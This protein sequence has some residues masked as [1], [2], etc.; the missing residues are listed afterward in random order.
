MDEEP[1]SH[2]LFRLFCLICGAPFSLAG[3]LLVYVA[4]DQWLNYYG[5]EGVWIIIPSEI[6]WTI[7]VALL[8]SGCVL[9][10]FVFRRKTVWPGSRPVTFSAS[11]PIP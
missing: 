4:T 3:L 2:P 9:L 5:V 7:G 11:R 1:V 10:Y 6:M 8:L